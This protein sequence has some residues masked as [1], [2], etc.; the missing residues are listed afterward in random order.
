MKFE[1]PSVTLRAFSRNCVGIAITEVHPAQVRD[2]IFGSG[3]VTSAVPQ[4][5]A[6]LRSF[7]RFAISRKI[8]TCDP[9]P[10]YTPKL[11]H[12]FT[13]HI[14]SRDDIAA[15]LAATGELRGRLQPHTLRTIILS[16][17]GAGMRIGEA[18]SLTVADVDLTAAVL[19]IRNGKFYKDRLLPIAADLG[20]ALQNYFAMRILLGQPEAPASPFFVT[21]DGQ[22]VTRQLA[23]QSFRKLCRLA[24]LWRFDE[25][26][27]QPRLHDLRHSF[28]VHRVVACY[29]VGGNLNLLL[30]KLSAYLGHTRL[31]YTQ[32]YLTM[33]PELLEQAGLRFERYAMPEERQ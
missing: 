19:T 10:A 27:Y 23:D 2:F 22:R 17:Y 6:T 28:A 24:G 32:R 21:E 25:S 8:V 18:L 13:P 4:R 9:L 20:F 11:G 29:R 26:R 16:L 14:Y 33:T 12:R 5:L 3:P 15:L 1:S 31:S 7:Y 30:P